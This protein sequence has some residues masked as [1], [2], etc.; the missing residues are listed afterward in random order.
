VII[1]IRHF[2]SF[3]RQSRAVWLALAVISYYLLTI[4][5]L[6]AFTADLS[7]GEVAI[8]LESVPERV[9]P[10]RDFMLTVTV[11]APEHL[12]VTLPDLRDRFAGFS[13]A[14]DFAAQPVAAN[15]RKRQTYRWRLV[16]EPAAKRYRLAPFAV[17]VTDASHSST[18]ATRPVIFPDEGARPPVT[19]DPEVNPEPLYVPPTARTVALWIVAVL[20]GVAALA[21]A[22]FGLT[23]LSRRVRE[24]RMPPADRAM[25]ELQRLL[26]RNLPT[27]GLFK[28]FYIELTMVVRRYIERTRGIRAPGQT[29]QEFLAVAVDHPSF[30]PEVVAK[31][32]TFLESA[33]LVKFA[34]QKATTEMTD[35]ATDR[36]RT[37]IRED[38]ERLQAPTPKS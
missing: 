27:R 2:R 34:G 20:A 29:T 13:M 24:F 14:E 3:R 26:G 19:G 32:K 33:D 12:E 21:A 38:A 11:E 8:K 4:H 15:G 6:F 37:Y 5:S 17:T 1:A 7:H 16:P 25:L 31:L 30:T 35:A 9:S 28:E 23:R 18:F 10:A 22:L 36:A